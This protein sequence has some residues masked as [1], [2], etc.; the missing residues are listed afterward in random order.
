MSFYVH[1]NAIRARVMAGLQARQDVAVRAL[2]PSYP[3][4]SETRS[5][6]SDL[7]RLE[8]PVVSVDDTFFLRLPEVLDELYRT[9]ARADV[10]LFI[11]CGI[12]ITHVALAALLLLQH[13]FHGLWLQHHQMPLGLCE[14]LSTYDYRR[15]RFS[16]PLDYDSL[17]SSGTSTTRCFS[18]ISKH[19]CQLI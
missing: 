4:M 15:V 19:I 3:W 6:I 7:Y 18:L 5:G 11:E 13:H 1:H 10:L 17:E 16:R 2:P 14:Y 12:C 8:F 9:D